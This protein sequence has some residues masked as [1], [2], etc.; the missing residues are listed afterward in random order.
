MAT[1]PCNSYCCWFLAILDLISSFLNLKAIY[2][3]LSFST[4]LFADTSSFDWIDFC[5]NR[6]ARLR[7]AFKLIKQTHQAKTHAESE[8]T[9]HVGDERR[10]RHSLVTHDVRRE[11]V[12]DVDVQPEQVVASVRVQLLRGLP[13]VLVRLQEPLGR[14]AGQVGRAMLVQEGDVVAE[15]WILAE[16]NVFLDLE[17]VAERG[18]DQPL[19]GPIL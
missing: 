11:R 9:T 2:V 6:I 1:G 13:P 16:Q 15:R 17:L 3:F 10:S 7:E 8:Q 5:V 19:G 4:F 14:G 12:F 18:I